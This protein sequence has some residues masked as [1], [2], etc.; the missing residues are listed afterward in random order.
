MALRPVN[1]EAVEKTMQILLTY[2]DDPVNVTPNNI[3]E[4]IVS[5]KSLI[6]G[7][8]GGGLFICQNEPESKLENPER[9]PD[10]D[11][12]GRGEPADA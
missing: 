10:E 7:I 5:A 1:Q 4:G 11:V 3:L 9:E 2:L 6:R 12:E 8:L